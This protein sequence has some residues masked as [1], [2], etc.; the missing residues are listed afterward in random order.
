ME[1][2][3][4]VLPA[5]GE[6]R[7]RAARRR[8]ARRRRRGR[9]ARP[10][11]VAE[12]KADLRLV[13]VIAPRGG[14]AAPLGAGRA[15]A[16]LE[17]SFVSVREREVREYLAAAREELGH[18]GCRPRALPHEPAARASTRQYGRIPRRAVRSATS[19]RSSRHSARRA[20]STGCSRPRGRRLARPARRS[21]ARRRRRRSQ[22]PPTGSSTTAEQKLLVRRGAGLVGR[23]RRRCSTR[24]GRCSTPRRTRTGM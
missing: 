9:A 10:A 2:V 13:E 5:L 3:S 22:R 14:A 8:R 1:Y 6:R 4:H 24:R 23:R 11:R 7:R 12:L 20:I 15:R 18:D 16:R 17:G 21:A 19:T